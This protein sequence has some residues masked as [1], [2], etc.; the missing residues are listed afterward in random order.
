MLYFNSHRPTQ[1]EEGLGPIPGRSPINTCRMNE[2]S[3]EVRKQ[4]SSDKILTVDLI[5]FL[6]P[7]TLP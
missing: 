2:V 3:K 7:S 1:R 6:K 4:I 5:H